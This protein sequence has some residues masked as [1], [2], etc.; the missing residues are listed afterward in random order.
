MNTA[1]TILNQ[2]KAGTDV[3]GY[4]VQI[5]TETQFLPLAA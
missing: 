3:Q 1:Q 5:W 4:N 2:I